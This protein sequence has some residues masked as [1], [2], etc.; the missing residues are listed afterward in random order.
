[1]IE[2]C[3]AEFVMVERR[4]RG[5]VNKLLLRDIM[6]SVRSELVEGSRGANH[7]DNFTAVMVRQAHHE[8]IGG[9]FATNGFSNIRAS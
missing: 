1:L 3:H 6:I 2:D 8:R 9:V 5:G 7:I 4:I